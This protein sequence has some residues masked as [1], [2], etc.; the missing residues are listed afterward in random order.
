MFPKIGF[1]FFI[2]ADVL[3]QP[4]AQWHPPR[5]HSGTSIC[6]FDY[7]RVTAMPVQLVV[8]QTSKVAR[9]PNDSAKPMLRRLGSYFLPHAK[10]VDVGSCSASV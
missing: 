10:S 5:P 3:A 8:H 9:G 2:P 7:P 4:D 6:T 1:P